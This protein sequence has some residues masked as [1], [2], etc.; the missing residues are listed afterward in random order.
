MS[1]NDKHQ[2]SNFISHSLKI[3]INEL[4]TKKVFNNKKNSQRLQSQIDQLGHCSIIH[5]SNNI[6][7]RQERRPKA[8]YDKQ[9]SGDNG[10]YH[11]VQPLLHFTSIPLIP[12]DHICMAYLLD[13]SFVPQVLK[14]KEAVL[15]LHHHDVLVLT[16]HYTIDY[17]PIK[18]PRR[19][20]PLKPELHYFN[21]SGTIDCQRMLCSTIYINIVKL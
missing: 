16:I 20:S 2:D 7:R 11:E 19:H 18:S 6:T 3:H 12:Q 8:Y 15:S 10:K 13:D 5:N 21:S 1:N 17:I 9:N 14:I 4:T